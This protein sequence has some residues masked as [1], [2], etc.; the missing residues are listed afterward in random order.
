MT[1]L[2]L[3]LRELGFASESG[4][5]ARRQCTH[6]WVRNGHNDSGTQRYICQACHERR[7]DGSRTRK[8]I[9][10]RAL[11]LAPLFG[12]G[13]TACASSRLT[14]LNLRTVQY[15]YQFLRR[16]YSPMCPCGKPS[17]HREGCSAR[18]RAGKAVPLGA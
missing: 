18:R 1:D 2:A 15:I 5:F 6:H 12:A 8:P 14:G 7:T 10:E 11:E 3:A 13:T 16:F 9:F 17:N 4:I